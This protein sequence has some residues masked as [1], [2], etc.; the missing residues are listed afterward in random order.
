VNA[1]KFVIM[2]AGKL[3]VRLV[4]LSNTFA[5]CELKEAKRFYDRDAASAQGRKAGILP[6]NLT[7][8]SEAE[9]E[10][11]I[12]LINRTC[13]DCKKVHEPFCNAKPKQAEAM[14]AHE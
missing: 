2:Y 12:D 8:M 9:A 10:A 11:F 6:H 1:T 5:L 7:V 13:P 3:P 4:D 14:C